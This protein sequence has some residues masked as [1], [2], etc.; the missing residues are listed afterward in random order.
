M[1]A[2]TYK[3]VVVN[4]SLIKFYGRL[5]KYIHAYNNKTS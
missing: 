3:H 5:E 2:T 1:H 4:W